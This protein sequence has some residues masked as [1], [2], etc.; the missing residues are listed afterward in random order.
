MRSACGVEPA[1]RETSVQPGETGPSDIAVSDQGEV[2]LRG[3]V[4]DLEGRFGT[5]SVAVATACADLAG[6]LAVNGEFEEA[7][8]LYERAATIERAAFGPGSRLASTLHDLAV[9][10][11]TLGSGE[12]ASALWAEAREMLEAGDAPGAVS[13]DGALLSASERPSIVDAR[14]NYDTTSYDMTEGDRS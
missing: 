4:A 12:E 2:H 13:G 7:A 1:D 11:Q 5:Q 6:L 9:I 8:Q 14:S 3:L 10:R